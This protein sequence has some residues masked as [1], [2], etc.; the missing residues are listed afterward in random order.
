MVLNRRRSLPILEANVITCPGRTATG[1]VATFPRFCGR[2]GY[3]HREHAHAMHTAKL[4]LAGV[5]R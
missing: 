5:L 4:I 3:S 2:I 1:L